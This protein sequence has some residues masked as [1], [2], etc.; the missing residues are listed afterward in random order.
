MSGNLLQ[1][2]VSGDNVL[3]RTGD[4]TRQELVILGIAANGFRQWRGADYFCAHREKIQNPGDVNTGEFLR[5]NRRQAAIRGAAA[6][7]SQNLI[8]RE[9]PW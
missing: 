5:N 4:S 9:G 2:P 7:Q 1:L 6:P 8:P 3:R